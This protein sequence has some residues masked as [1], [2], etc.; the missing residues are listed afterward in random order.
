MSQPDALF[1]IVP[2][3][4]LPTQLAATAYIFMFVLGTVA[5][6]GGYTAIIGLCLCSMQR[7]HASFHHNIHYRPCAVRVVY[8]SVGCCNA[9]CIGRQTVICLKS[10][11]H[12]RD[13]EGDPGA[14]PVVDDKSVGAG[15]LRSNR[16]WCVSAGRRLGLDSQHACVTHVVT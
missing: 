12:R 7:F 9:L 1:V 11:A 13:I 5:A 6:M 8:T 14:Q 15:L 10:R 4:T 3:L 16:Y 2:A